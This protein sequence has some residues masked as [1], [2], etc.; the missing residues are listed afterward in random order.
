MAEAKTGYVEVAKGVELF[1]RE[2]GTG[3][4][5]VFV[6]G[7]TF[8]SAVFE[9]QLEELSRARRVIAIDPRG[10]GNSTKVAVGNSY[11]IHGHDLG[12]FLEKLG[13]EK[14]VLVGWSTGCLEA[15]AMVR[16]HG[17]GNL[18]GFIGIDMSFKALSSS[19]DDWVEGSVEEAAEVSTELL[20]TEEGQ[21]AFIEMYAKEVM[22]QR[23]LTQTELDWITDD[24]L[25]TPT[26]AALALWGSAMLADYSKEAAAMDRDV[27]SLYILAEHWADTAKPFLAKHMP[28]TETR[29][30]GGHMMFWEHAER[31]NALVDEFV[32]GLG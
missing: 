21:R 6:P 2:A 25:K 22:I 18:A 3:A 13:V 29:T 17:T 8:S 11:N 28:N 5:I 12:V 32:K 19:S 10:Q 26:W 27:P 31:F 24:S 16:A 1:Y 14:P 15:Y 20:G 9:R 7:W 23:E 4:P 30:L